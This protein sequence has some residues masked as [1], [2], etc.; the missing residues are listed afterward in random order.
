MAKRLSLSGLNLNFKEIADLFNIRKESLIFYYSSK[1]PNFNGIFVGYTKKE[2]EDE[3]NYNLNEIEK[4]AC[5]NLLASIEAI[6][7]IDYAI[8]C[9]RKRKETISRKFRELF[10][11]YQHRMPLEES[12]LETWK[13]HFPDKKHIISE[14][15]GAFKY[16][17]WLAHGRYWEL[18]AERKDY[19][20]FELYLLS[21]ELKNELPLLYI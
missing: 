13:E 2:I 4:D 14:L 5:L 1:N 12:L 21:L 16:R 8:R 9:E 17:H 3:L 6:F 10:N 19:D 15:K 18:K 20:F 7:R 11:E